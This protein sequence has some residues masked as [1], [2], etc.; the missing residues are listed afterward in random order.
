MLKICSFQKHE[1]THSISI[2]RMLIRS[3]CDLYKVDYVFFSCI[4]G[5]FMFGPHNFWTPLI[6]SLNWNWMCTHNIAQ[7][8]GLFLLPLPVHC[9]TLNKSMIID[10]LLYSPSNCLFLYFTGA[11]CKEALG[12]KRNCIVISKRDRWGT[13]KE[14]IQETPWASKGTIWHEFCQNWSLFVLLPLYRSF[15]K[16]ADPWPIL[17][18]ISRTKQKWSC[19]QFCSLWSQEHNL[20]WM[21]FI[22]QLQFNK[23]LPTYIV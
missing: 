8:I 14:I 4:L 2:F 20:K 23:W 21:T 11:V 16:F 12:L 15:E 7:Q 5:S 6:C 17:T 13:A 9:V 22:T 18:Y 1:A 10:I 19:G 3:H